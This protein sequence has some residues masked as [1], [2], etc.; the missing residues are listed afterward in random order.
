MFKKRFE[1][2]EEVSKTLELKAYVTGHIMKLEDVPDPV[3]AEQMMGD[4]IAIVPVEG[5]IIS[6]VNGEIVNVFPAKHAIGIKT[7]NGVEILIHIGLETVS[8]NG[9]GFTVHVGEGK[10]VKVGDALVTVDLDLVKNKAKSTVIPII[11]TNTN[12]M[13]SIEK[14][15]LSGKVTAANETILAVT[16]K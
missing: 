6:P 15:I 10:K 11:I 8:M 14:P 16:A 1:K 4:G 13:R 12:A 2:K 7:A 3:F 5:K 9:E